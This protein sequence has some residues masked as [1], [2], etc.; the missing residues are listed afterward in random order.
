MSKRELI[1][2]ELDRLPEQDLD[3]LIGYLHAIHGT[4]CDAAGRQRAAG[5][6]AARN[7][8]ASEE[9]AAWVELGET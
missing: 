4:Q 5:V 6:E 8:F 7:W 2:N 1:V 3:W 9:A